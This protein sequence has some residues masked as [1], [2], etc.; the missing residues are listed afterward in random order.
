MRL[1]PAEH[2]DESALVSE[3]IDKKCHFVLGDP[4]LGLDK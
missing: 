3:I 2:P 4:V 1:I